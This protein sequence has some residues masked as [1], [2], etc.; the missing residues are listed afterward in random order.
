MG[1]LIGIAA[2]FALFGASAANA[3][4]LAGD[5]TSDNFFTAYLSTSDSVLGTQI[6]TGND[7]TTT[8]SFSGQGLS[9]GVTN[10]LHVI[11]GN[12]GGPEMYV[13]DFT[14]SDTGFHFANGTQHI[15]TDTTNW[16]ASGAAASWFAPTGTPQSFDPSTWGTRPNIDAGALF[17]WSNPTGVND[18]A[19]FSTTITA[20]AVTHGV[21]EPGTLSILALGLLGFGALRR[22]KAVA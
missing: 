16:R 3:T 10:Y 2:A 15:A 5:N 7:W 19:F 6:D 12:G 1:K 11:A 22:R 14:L 18:E 21:P 13:G 8:Y 9:G 20:A 17:I 4:T